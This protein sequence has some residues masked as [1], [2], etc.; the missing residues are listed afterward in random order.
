MSDESA[1]AEEAEVEAV[2]AMLV[3]AKASIAVNDE[4]IAVC[5]PENF[6]EWTKFKMEKTLQKAKN[7]SATATIRK[8]AAVQQLEDAAARR[9]MTA[10]IDEVNAGV[11]AAIAANKDFAS[12]TIDEAIGMIPKASASTA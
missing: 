10:I 3:K 2:D 6:D 8:L 7:D 12:Q 11:E 5:A 9:K 4:L 1:A